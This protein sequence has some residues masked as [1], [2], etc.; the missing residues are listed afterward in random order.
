VIEHSDPLWVSAP[1]T[2]LVLPDATPVGGSKIP[3]RIRRRRGTWPSRLRRA[4]GFAVLLGI[5]YFLVSLFQVWSTGRADQTAPVEA[6]VVLGAAQYDGEPSPQ[7]AARLDHV[8]ELFNEGRAPLV[9]TTGGK[10]PADRFTESEA[11][12]EYLIERG[13]PAEV[14][15]QETQGRSTWESMEGVAEILEERGI[16][17]VLLVSDPYHMLRSKLIAEEVGLDPWVSATR[18]SPVRRWTAVLR[19]VKEAGGV[20]VGRLI[21]FERLWN[22][23]G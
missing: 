6:I 7:L 15:I 16:S 8:V 10:L 2:S 9:V 19:H 23:T 21:G 12:A 22:V 14:I 18:T 1:M 17:K 13:V 5:G 11:S 3:R 20:A 4:F